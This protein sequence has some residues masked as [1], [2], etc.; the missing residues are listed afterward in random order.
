L[1]L[2]ELPLVLELVLVGPVLFSLSDETGLAVE[3]IRWLLSFFG[4]T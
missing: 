4:L 1:K 2:L 3:V